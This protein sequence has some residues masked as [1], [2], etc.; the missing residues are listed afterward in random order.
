[1]AV[2]RQNDVHATQMTSLCPT[3]F[4]LRI[5][6]LERTTRTSSSL[7]LHVR[8]TEKPRR[9]EPPPSI[10][11]PSRNRVHF[12]CRSHACKDS[13]FTCLRKRREDVT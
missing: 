6:Q 8:S 1:M 12:Y 13:F 7:G 2:E 9:S 11:V 3:P 4:L 10:R 5:P